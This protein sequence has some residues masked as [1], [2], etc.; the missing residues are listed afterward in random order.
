MRFTLEF[1]RIKKEVV[2]IYDQIC[3]IHV[4]KLNKLELANAKEAMEF[5]NSKMYGIKR[6]IEKLAKNEKERNAAQ[7]SFWH[8]S[9]ERNIQVLKDYLAKCQEIYEKKIAEIRKRS[10]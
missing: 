4:G 6:K 5:L 9:H 8:K 1:V 2:R 3:D 7:N 10:H